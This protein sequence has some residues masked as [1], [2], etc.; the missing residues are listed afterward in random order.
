MPITESGESAAVRER[1]EDVVEDT[2]LEVGFHVS[3]RQAADDEIGF[4]A[5]AVNVMGEVFGRVIDDVQAWEAPAELR[6][7][8]GVELDDEEFGLVAQPIQDE[9]SE[10]A[11]AW[12]K[13]DDEARAAEI[14]F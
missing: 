7:A 2:I 1:A 14:A 6:R 10:G 12:A 11:R 8:V 4:L 13:F 3:P 5:D 9:P